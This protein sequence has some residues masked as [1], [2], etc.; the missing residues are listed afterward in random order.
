MSLNLSNVDHEPIDIV[1]RA[2][3]SYSPLRRKEDESG[4]KRA[5]N[6]RGRGSH[7]VTTRDVLPCPLAISVLELKCYYVSDTFRLSAYFSLSSLSL[8]LSLPLSLFL[9]SS[10]VSRLSC[11]KC[12]FESVLNEMR[13][14][15]DAWRDEKE[16]TTTKIF[17][18]FEVESLARKGEETWK[19]ETSKLVNSARVSFYLFFLQSP[20]DRRSAIRLRHSHFSE[21]RIK[22]GSTRSG[23]DRVEK[24]CLW[25]RG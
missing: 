19:N 9:H 11:R 21:N 15:G 4:R 25:L 20:P 16:K 13:E 23:L 2:P 1:S 12:D 18:G 7:P 24:S 5:K 17:G 14:T 8:S 10:R 22:S 3:R 6:E